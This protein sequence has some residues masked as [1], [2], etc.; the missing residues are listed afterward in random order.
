MPATTAGRGPPATW[1]RWCARAAP[2]L[3]AR[4][5]CSTTTWW[6]PPT[7]GAARSIRRR[8]PR[9][10]RITGWSGVFGVWPVAADL[11]NTRG[12]KVERVGVGANAGMS[13]TFQA[14]TAAQRIVLGR[15]LDA[16]YVDFPRQVGEARKLEPGPLDAA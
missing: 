7:T 1:W 10:G 15:E 13:S 11:L 14:P 12:V 2:S 9:A 5:A 3:L 4:A 16:V 6:R 8:A